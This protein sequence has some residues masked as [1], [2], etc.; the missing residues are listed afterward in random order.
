MA[1]S[2]LFRYPVGQPAPAGTRVGAAGL[3]RGGLRDPL[4]R[5]LVVRRIQRR[6]TGLIAAP[7]GSGVLVAGTGVG[8]VVYCRR[9][10]NRKN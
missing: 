6:Y 9:Q 7:V 4:S 5:H 1:R 8:M 2:Q 10:I 3:R